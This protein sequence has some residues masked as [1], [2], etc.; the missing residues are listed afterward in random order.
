ML[1]HNVRRWTIKQRLIGSMLLTSGVVLAITLGTFFIY[2]LVTFRQELLSDL[3]RLARVMAANSATALAFDNREDAEA[4]LSALAADSDLAAAAIYNRQGAILAS[5]RTQSDVAIPARAEPDGSRISSGRLTVNEPVVRG[6]NERLGTLYLQSDLSALYD[7]LTVYATLMAAVLVA[8]T[9]VAVVLASRLQ[10]YISRPV[11]ALVETAATVAERGDYSVRARWFA[12]DELGRLTD[13][14]NNML[15]R[16]QGQDETLRAR[17]QHLKREVADRT[18]AEAEVMSLNTE[19]EHRVE[20]RTRA[21]EA[22]NKELE[23]FSYSVSHDLRAPL[24]AITGFSRVLLDDYI[25]ELSPE[26]AG[27]LRRVAGGADRMGQ[28]IDDLLEFARLGRA[29]LTRRRMDPT[30]LARQV[31]AELTEG[32]TDLP[33]IALASLP[34]CDAD[35]ALL[36]QVY[37]N[38]VSNALKFTRHRHDARIEIGATTAAD[39][40]VV[41]HV[42]DNGAGFDMKYAS[43]L[44]GVFQRLH[45]AEDYEGTGVGLAIVQRVIA[46]HGGRV[47]AEAALDQGARFYFTIGERA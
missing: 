32:R 1:R 19:L 18:R 16:I 23:A 46:R 29:S 8:G 6:G 44:F 31:V 36:K 11:F 2:E 41:Y 27:Y 37:V 10:G 15:A 4:V 28:L 30:P 5:Y 47:W 21:L 13:G 24:R 38:L 3:S 33:A 17:E 34:E 20:Q 25:G 40:A 35:A 39:G 14:F 7:R 45:R 26:A 43:K 12:D 22:A 42:K 9:G